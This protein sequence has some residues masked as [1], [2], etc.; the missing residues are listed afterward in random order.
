MLKVDPHTIFSP[1]PYQQFYPL[2]KKW[3]IRDPLIQKNAFSIPL[4]TT[5][6]HF[7]DPLYKKLHFLESIYNKNG[8]FETPY[9]KIAFYRPPIQKMPFIPNNFSGYNLLH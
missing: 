2:Y 8:T 6:W 5:K 7:R 1:L 9:T 4:N 3:H